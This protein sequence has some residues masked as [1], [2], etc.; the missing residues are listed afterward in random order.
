MCGIKQFNLKRIK[1]PSQWRIQ[2]F[3]QGGL[4]FFFQGGAQHP[5]GHENPLKSID[6][7]GL[8]GA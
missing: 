8:W 4:K 6:F 7:T 1:L 3:V 5:L 2:E